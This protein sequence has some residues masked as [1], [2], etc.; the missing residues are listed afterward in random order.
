MGEI[1]PKSRIKMSQLKQR[2]VSTL[3]DQIGALKAQK[4]ALISGLSG[5]NGRFATSFDGAQVSCLLPCFGSSPFVVAL[6]K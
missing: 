5:A 3:L 1:Q 2:V 6:K 4:A